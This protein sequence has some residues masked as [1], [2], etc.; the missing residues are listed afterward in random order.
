[1]LTAMHCLLLLFQQLAAVVLLI[2][3][4]PTSGLWA[5]PLL[6]WRQESHHSLRYSP[7]RIINKFLL[8]C[9]NNHCHCSA[10]IFYIV[11]RPSFLLSDSDYGVVS[12]RD[13]IGGYCQCQCQ[14]QSWIYI[15]HK[16]KASNAL[17]R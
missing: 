6:R 16:C 10:R 5:A 7:H 1:M 14:C 12:V 9:L 15:A 11:K 8:F 17:V 3:C 13:D 2:G 4:R